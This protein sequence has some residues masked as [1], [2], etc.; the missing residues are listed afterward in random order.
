LI[1]TAEYGIMYLHSV[2]RPCGEMVDALRLDRSECNAHESS[3][4]S[5]ATDALHPRAQGFSYAERKISEK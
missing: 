3:N 1:S 4:L 2:T 5:E